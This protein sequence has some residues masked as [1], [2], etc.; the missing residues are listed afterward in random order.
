M[1]DEDLL[2]PE[3]SLG[4]IIRLTSGHHP[5]VSSDFALSGKSVKEDK[6]MNL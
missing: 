1:V 3:T 6:E 4:E 2:C 5:S